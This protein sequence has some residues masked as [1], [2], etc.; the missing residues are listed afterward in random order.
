MYIN[1]FAFQLRKQ[2]INIGQA[3][4]RPGPPLDTHCK[5]HIHTCTYKHHIATY[6]PYTVAGNFQGR[7]YSRL[8]FNDRF[9][10]LIIIVILLF[11]R[12]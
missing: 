2:G 4:A 3:H 7:E 11:S 8:S 10:E 5:Q 12:I 9:H 6:V 1:L